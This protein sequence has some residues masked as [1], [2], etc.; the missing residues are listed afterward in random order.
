[1]KLKNRLFL[2]NKFNQKKILLSKMILIKN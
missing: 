1:M 2:I